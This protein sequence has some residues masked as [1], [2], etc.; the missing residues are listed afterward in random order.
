MKGEFID[1]SQVAHLHETTAQIVGVSRGQD[2]YKKLSSK[3]CLKIYDMICCNLSFDLHTVT[4]IN[5]IYFCLNSLF[6]LLKFTLSMDL[7]L[8]KI[9]LMN[10]LKVLTLKNN[11]MPLLELSRKLLP[12]WLKSKLLPLSS[13]SMR[14]QRT[15]KLRLLKSQ[16]QDTAELIDEFKLITFSVW[17]IPKPDAWP[18]KV[19]TE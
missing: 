9:L 13:E 7:P 16:F 1:H 8:H 11:I 4:N 18:S 17:L 15:K 12:V 3:K 2:M 6:H 10:N 5:L 19:K 14:S